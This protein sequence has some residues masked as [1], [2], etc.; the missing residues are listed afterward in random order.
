[1]DLDIT[2]SPEV[3]KA[4]A[5]AEKNIKQL[6]IGTAVVVIGA[7]VIGYTFWSRANQRKAAG[8]AL[9]DTF[10][11]AT[12]MTAAE[13]EAAYTKVA[14]EYRS[15][16]AGAQ[17]RLLAAAALFDTGKFSE[18]QVAFEQF[19]NEHFSSPLT[20]Q[21][22]YGKAAALSAQGKTSEAADAYKSVVDQFP[23]APL[24]SQAR[25]ALASLRAQQGDLN[26][27][28]SLYEEVARDASRSSL[29]AEAALRADELR[30]KL[31]PPVV[32]PTAAEINPPAVDSQSTTN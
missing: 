17:A 2:E 27:A 4:W 20:A 19:A 8:V 1:M 7:L 13:S 6:I 5:W 3:L 11:A 12:Q 30:A 18:A 26:Q 25:Y 22:L 16:P 24:V 15:T 29:G 32:V 23:Q 9:A 31:P 10:Y 28:V 14:D 21:A